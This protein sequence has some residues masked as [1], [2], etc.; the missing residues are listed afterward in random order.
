MGC[1]LIVQAVNQCK[2][3]QKV[4][5]GNIYVTSLLHPDLE[6]V[7]IPIKGCSQLRLNQLLTIY[8]GVHITYFNLI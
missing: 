7:I 1:K 6:I 3:P 5:C 4:V 2:A 8:Q